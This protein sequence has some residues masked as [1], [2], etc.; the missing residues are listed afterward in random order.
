MAP[1]YIMQNII[2]LTHLNYS[3][4]GWRSLVKRDGLKI[5]WLR[6]TGVQNIF[7]DKSPSL[8]I[9]KLLVLLYGIS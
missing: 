5:R 7:M 6:S 3:A 1:F 9:K 8:H 4:Q 2:Y